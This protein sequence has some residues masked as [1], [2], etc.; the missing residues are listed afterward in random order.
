MPSETEDE[1]SLGLFGLT[2]VWE[3]GIPAAASLG[4]W[5]ELTGPGSALMAA[6][7]SKP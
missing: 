3:A 1:S 7:L 2:L 5:Q 4:V 6:V